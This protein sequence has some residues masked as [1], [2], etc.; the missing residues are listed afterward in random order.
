AIDSG[1]HFNISANTSITIAFGIVLAL[2]FIIMINML[3]K[4]KITLKV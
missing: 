3:K 4:S 1:D 2:A